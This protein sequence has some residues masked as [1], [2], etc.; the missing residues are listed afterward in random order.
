MTPNQ[1]LEEMSVVYAH[2]VAVACGSGIKFEYERIDDRCVDVKIIATKPPLHGGASNIQVL[3]QL[4]STQ[5]AEFDGDDL[6][7]EVNRRLYDHMTGLT[8]SDYILVVFLVP[9]DASLAVTWSAEHISIAKCAYWYAF[10]SD[11]VWPGVQKTTTI[12]IPTRQDF[13]PTHLKGLL[14]DTCRTV[15]LQKYGIQL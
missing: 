15:T 14:D 12:R 5:H 4:K 9:D 10:P 6:K 8:G 13:N 1:L 7:L 2:A 11:F 3:V